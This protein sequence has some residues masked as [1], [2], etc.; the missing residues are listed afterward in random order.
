MNKILRGRQASISELNSMLQNYS[1]FSTDSFWYVSRLET[2]ENFDKSEK[3]IFAESLLLRS[4]YVKANIIV[5]LKMDMK[6][7]RTQTPCLSICLS[8]FSAILFNI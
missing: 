2:L 1:F 6:L 8:I 7:T 5:S 3:V 4:L